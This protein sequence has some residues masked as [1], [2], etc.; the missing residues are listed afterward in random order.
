MQLMGSVP[1]AVPATA[2]LTEAAALLEQS[3]E[4]VV[5]LVDGEGSYL[6]TVTARAVTEALAGGEP[7]DSPV[8]TV[9]ERPEAIRVTAPL[10]DAIVLLDRGD[11]SAVPVLDE[12]GRELVGWVTHQ[13]ALNALYRAR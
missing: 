2:S 12:S 1:P 9:A 8:T 3:S 7:A 13:V 4:P 5:P 6:G 10:D 11:A